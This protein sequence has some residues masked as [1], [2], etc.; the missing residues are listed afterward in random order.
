MIFQ[1]YEVTPNYCYEYI[2]IIDEYEFM[3]SHML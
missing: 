3:S 2:G 1:Q